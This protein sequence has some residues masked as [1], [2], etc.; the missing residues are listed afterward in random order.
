MNLKIFAYSIFYLFSILAHA[1]MGMSGMI[2]NQITR[3]VNDAIAKNLFDNLIIPQLKVKNSSGHIIEMQLSANQRFLSLVLED[4]TARVW[5]LDVGVQRPMIKAKNGAIKA[6][7][8]TAQQNTLYVANGS[9]VDSYDFLSAT[10]VSS[11]SINI[12]QIHGMVSTPDNSLLIINHGNNELTA[13]GIQSKRQQWTSQVSEGDTQQMRIAPNKQNFAILV[14]TPTLF[15]SSDQLE[16]RDLSTG[17]ISKVL[18]NDGE[19]IIAFEFLQ[20]GVLES[21]YANGD[22]ISWNIST[23]NQLSSTNT[24]HSVLATSKTANRV[25]AYVID[26]DNIS[27]VNPQ[28]KPISRISKKDIGTQSLKLLANGNKLLTANSDGKAVLWD[29]KT[30]SKVLQ[31]ISTKQGWSIVDSLGRFDSSEKGMPNISWEAED[32]E[33][34]IDSFSKKYYEPGLLAT[35][36]KNEA[37]LNKD[38]AAIEKGIALPPELEVV[39]KNIKT[40]RHYT[41]LTVEVTGQGGG[42][43]SV[44]LY[45]NSKVVAGK[46][47]I[48]DD[49]VFEKDGREHRSMRM[50]VTPTTGK[51]SIKVIAS[52]KMGIEGQSKVLQFN[53]KKAVKKVAIK[54]ILKVITIGVNQYR[55]SQLNLD[56]SVPDAQ[57]ISKLLN[58]NDISQFR[59]VEKRQLYNSSATK[60]SILSELNNLSNGAANDVLAIYFAGHGIS[61]DGEWYFLPHETQ[62]QPD[63]SYFTRVGISASELSSIFVDSKIQQIL[64]MVDACYSGASVDSF[65]RLQ[66]SQRHFSRDMSKSVGI[67]VITATRKDQ[68]A[69]ELSELG[70]GLFTYVLSKGMTGQADWWPKNNEVSAH[71]LAKFSTDTIPLFSKKYLGAAQEP[72]AFTMGKDFALISI[73]K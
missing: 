45:H 34:P 64:L 61:V 65:R 28:G 44:D 30:G 1:D 21:T 48:L 70:H 22:I 20:T 37:Y 9:S 41:E 60:L 8:A 36:L 68:E 3:T 27:I 26:N 57:S 66:N 39:V 17:A 40:T 69:A 14:R 29:T 12:P 67:T 7:A 71:E 72:T 59:K 43:D 46:R 19:K 51:N 52:N 63:M 4:G 25:T 24:G 42:I 6:I 18:N 31:I 56:Y 47:A 16:I 32:K 10:L 53:I 50:K 33:I 73:K 11:L 2:T 62:L 35:A 13:W 49:K 58:N 23:G 38:P 54:P 5:D 15:S 55:D